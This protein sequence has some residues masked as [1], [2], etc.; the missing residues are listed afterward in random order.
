MANSR[1]F[2]QRK[3]YEFSFD[4][5]TLK[6]NVRRDEHGRIHVPLYSN[7]FTSMGENILCT[8]S[9]YANLR[10]DIQVSVDIYP[11]DEK[12]TLDVF[13]PGQS[14][15]FDRERVILGFRRYINAC[16]SNFRREHRTRLLLFSAFLF[17]GVFIIF[18]KYV[19][20]SSNTATWIGA[21]M[22]TTGC[23]FIWQLMGYL[24]FTLP[25]EIRMLKRYYQLLN[26]DF[27]FK[28]WE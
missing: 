20:I 22:E 12:I 11:P 18:A 21:C 6:N 27:S 26:L 4:M 2:F 25:G 13:E 1:N 9:M 5:R 24:A 23:L 28:T 8:N 14:S 10:N 3:V 7:L 19:L 16:Y 15:D 17:I